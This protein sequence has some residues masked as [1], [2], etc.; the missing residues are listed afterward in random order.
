MEIHRCVRSL[1]VLPYWKGSECATFL[2]YVGVAF[3]KHFLVKSQYINFLDLFCATTICS[4]EYFSRFLPV[5]QVHFE[6]YIKCFRQTFRCISSNIHNLVHVTS[7]VERFGPLDT[8]SSYPF[9]NQLFNV[10]K[11]L[12][13]GKNPLQ[14][15]INRITEE[16]LVTNF[17]DSSNL[18]KYPHYKK[19]EANTSKFHHMCLREG[20]N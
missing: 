9:E 1:H 16:T 6:D 3:F 14:Q 15:V 19:R 7:E 4:C 11:M 2:N 17:A 8:L 12:R 13:T 20:F 10:K 18:I 5:A